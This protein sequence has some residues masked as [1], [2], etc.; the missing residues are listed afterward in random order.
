ME[1]R[2]TIHFMSI[3]ADSGNKKLSSDRKKPLAEPGL[4]MG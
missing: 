1:N 4:S 3:S 2:K